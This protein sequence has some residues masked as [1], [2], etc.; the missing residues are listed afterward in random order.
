MGY[1]ADRGDTINVAS[2]AFADDGSGGPP[3]WKD[4]EIVALGK[5]GLNWLLVLVAILFAYRRDSPLLR[6]VAKPKPRKKKEPPRARKARKAKKGEEGVRVTRSGR[7]AT[8]VKRPGDLR[9]ASS[10]P[11]PRRATIPRWSPT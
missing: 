5:E 2:G 9:A 1:N 6:T 8:G 10:C 4:P 7:P 3:P 11:A